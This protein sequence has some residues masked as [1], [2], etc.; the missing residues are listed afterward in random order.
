MSRWIVVGRGGILD[1]AHVV[2]IARARSA[3]VKR[4]LEAA[5]PARVINLTYGYPRQSVV[6]LDNGFLA[7]VTLSVEDLARHLQ[8]E[9]EPDEPPC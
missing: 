7:V 9:E 1:A 4:L 5:G 3:P 8:L 2:A 6:L